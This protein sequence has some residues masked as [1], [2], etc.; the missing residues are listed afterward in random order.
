M[1]LT[2][3]LWVVT[4]SRAKDAR[5]RRQSEAGD[6]LLEV[7]LTLIVLGL[8]SVAIIIA[9]STSISASAEERNLVTISTVVRSTSESVFAQ[10]RQINLTFDSTC[11][12]SQSNYPAIVPSAPS[13]YKAIISSVQYLQN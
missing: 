10:F 12:A 9:V 5:S 1:K 3:R 7:L 8:S 6:T 4:V 11:S 13:G 2:R